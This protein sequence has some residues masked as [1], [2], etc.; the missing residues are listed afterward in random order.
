MCKVFSHDASGDMAF[1]EF[2][3]MIAVFSENAPNS[4]KI[5]Y[6]FRIYDTNNDDLLSSDDLKEVGISDYELDCDPS[7]RAYIQLHLV[8]WK[9]ECSFLFLIRKFRIN[10]CT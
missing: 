9:P 6:A 1:S 3:N 4:R 2:L 7:G 5:E 10:I 8:T